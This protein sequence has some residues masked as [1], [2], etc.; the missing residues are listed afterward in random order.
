MQTNFTAAQ[1]ADPDIARLRE[2]PARLRPLR[3]LH[4]DLPDLRAARRRARQPARPHLPDQGHAGERPARRRA[5]VVKHVDRC[6]SCLSCMT[7]CPSGVNYMHLV[8]HA[9]ASD[10]DDVSRGPW[11]TG[12]APRASALVLPR[13]GSVPPRPCRRRGWRAPS[14]R[15]PARSASAAPLALVP[16]Q[17]AAAPRPST[18]R[19]S[20]G[21]RDAGPA[22]RAAE[23]LRAAG[24]RARDQRGDDP[25]ADAPR[26][27]G[28]RRRGRGLLR[29]AHA[30][31]RTR[32]AAASRAPTSSPG[33]ARSIAAAS[34]RS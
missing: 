23:R 32:T 25:A 33:R 24:A 1:L 30:S 31:P 22:G 13:P 2:D 27:R 6:L 5:E 16:A 9:R 26:L 8:D 4:R 10:R 11:P 20:S 18:G 7:T 15:A 19:R 28:R 21:A 3:L 14:R 17:A 29:R 34:T 12:A